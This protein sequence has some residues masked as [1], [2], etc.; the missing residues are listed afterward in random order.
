MGG[1]SSSCSAEDIRGGFCLVDLG[2]GETTPAATEGG[3]EGNRCSS[4]PEV[5]ASSSSTSL[6]SAC[7]GSDLVPRR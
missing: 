3:E 6:S 5:L 7:S 2:K 4:G 1:S